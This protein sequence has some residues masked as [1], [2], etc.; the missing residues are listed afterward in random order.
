MPLAISIRQLQ[1]VIVKRLTKKFPDA[2]PPIPSQE[3]IRL[4]FWPANP[5]SD[6]AIRHTG[7]FK[8]KFGVQVRQLCKDHVD[9]HYVS[10][11]LQYVR[12]FAVQY[13][14]CMLLVSVDGKCIIP[15]GEPACPVS[16]GVRG[17][18][19]SLVSVHGP[20][21]QALDHDFHLY[22]IVPSVAFLSMC[23]KIHL[24]LFLLAIL[25]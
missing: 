9:R 17:H 5:F 3:W 11:L 6:R 12:S 23:L 20:Q 21:L 13:C 7:R 2:T 10:A 22:G 24:I 15:V 14:A 1:E 4:Q 8:V 18:N 25:L 16:T 19:R